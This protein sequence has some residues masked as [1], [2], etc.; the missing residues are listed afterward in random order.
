MESMRVRSFRD[1]RTW[2]EAH[3]LTLEVYKITSDFPPD[4]R[5]GLTNQL[6]RA[7]VSI[8][9]NIAEGMGRASTADVIRFFIQ[10]RGS[11]Q[12]V[13]YQLLLAKDLGYCMSKLAEGLI[14]RYNGLNAG[15]NAHIERLQATK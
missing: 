14:D 1:L 5:Y 4:E 7:S 10:A 2:N 11:V 13:S 12:E 8:P 15:I 6:R 9:S 3:L